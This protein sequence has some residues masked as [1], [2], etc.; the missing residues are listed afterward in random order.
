MKQFWSLWKVGAE[1]TLWLSHI[2]HICDKETDDTHR[3][4]LGNSG[5]E[6]HSDCPLHSER[7]WQGSLMDVSTRLPTRFWQISA[8]CRWMSTENPTKRFNNTHVMAFRQQRNQR[9]WGRKVGRG[10]IIIKKE[11][12]KRQYMYYQATLSNGF[13]SSS[14]THWWH[15]GCQQW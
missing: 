8:L 12:I 9:S 14:H 7:L 10:Y 6:N 13:F 2:V 3:G 4:W 11:K 5:E 15:Y 1:Y